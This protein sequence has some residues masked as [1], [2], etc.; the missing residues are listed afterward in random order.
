MSG[1]IERDVPIQEEN[2]M[3]IKLD[4]AVICAWPRHRKH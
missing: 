2:A 3:T 4:G 1:P